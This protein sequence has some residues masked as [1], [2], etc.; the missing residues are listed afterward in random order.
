MK[1]ATFLT[2]KIKNKFNSEKLH[3]VNNK[4]TEIL[5]NFSCNKKIQRKLELLATEILKMAYLRKK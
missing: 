2:M 4:N 5:I 1:I 3:N